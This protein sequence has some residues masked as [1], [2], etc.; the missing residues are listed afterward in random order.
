VNKRTWFWLVALA[1]FLTFPA[2]HLITASDG[3]KTP[4]EW[5]GA[6]SSRRDMALTT[7]IRTALTP[8]THALGQVES[9]RRTIIECELERIPMTGSDA[10]QLAGG[11][12]VLLSIVPDGQ[13]VKAGEVL[14]VLDAS[15]YVE[16]LRQQQIAVEQ[17]CSTFR[18]AE[19]NLEIARLAVKEYKDGLLEETLQGMNGEIALARS[20]VQR[21]SDRLAWSQKMKKKEYASVSQVLTD[22]NTLARMDFNLEQQESAR[23]LFVRFTVPKDLMV[24]EGDVKAAEANLKY[25]KQRLERS[26][27]RLALLERQV[28]KCTIRAPHD[29]MVVYANNPRRDIYIEPG[30]PVRQKQDLIYLPDLGQMQVVAQSHETIVDSISVGNEARIV[31]EAMPGHSVRG[32]VL[33][34][35]PVPIFERHLP[36]LRYFP[37]V[38]ALDEIP[39][40]LRPGMTAQV[41]IY[42]PKHEKA[43]VIP[44]QAV[45]W[46]NGQQV[47]YVPR[48]DQFERRK[49]VVGQ[50]TPEFVEVLGG[51]T[52]G[53]RVVLDPGTAL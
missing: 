19:L 52:E 42:L 49:L 13:V 33:S 3:S 8:S 45:C 1:G 23:D 28:E 39:P 44:Q 53:E 41:E 26:L 51:L 29:G 24:L 35:N 38:I 46:E 22:K 17:S 7:A 12:S 36:D 14:A 21:A 47:C 18:Q 32:R 48:G 30:M 31:F 25:E 15:T 6:S 2:A 40:G 37:C 5:F 43:L 9:A 50:T 4:L 34:I 16:M 20:D 27:G 11:A 10:S